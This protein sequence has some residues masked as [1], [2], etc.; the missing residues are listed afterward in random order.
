MLQGLHHPN[1]V[2]F[3]GIGVTS[4]RARFVV[5]ELMSGGSLESTLAMPSIDLKWSLRLSYALQIAQGYVHVE[6][7]SQLDFIELS[8]PFLWSQ[9]GSAPQDSTS[10]SKLEV[11]QRAV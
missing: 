5:T 10:T 11:G 6:V 8:L 4:A 7:H 2:R 3:L 1:L 9:D